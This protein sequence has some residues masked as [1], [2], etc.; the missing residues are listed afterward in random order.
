MIFRVAIE[1]NNEGYRSIA[2][3]LEHPGCYAY[4]EDADKALENLPKAIR[5]YSHW[6]GRHETP[7]VDAG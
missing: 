3:A 4:G 5:D 1:N 6:I 2:W 7:W